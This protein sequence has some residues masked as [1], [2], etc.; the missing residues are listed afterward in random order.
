MDPVLAWSVCWQASTTAAAGAAGAA[1]AFGRPP[2]PVEAPLSATM[3]C[4]TVNSVDHHHY[5]VLMECNNQG[6]VAFAGRDFTNAS[7]WFRQGI[8]LATFLSTPS[9]RRR[10]RRRRRAPSPITLSTT[11]ESVPRVAAAA[12]MTLDGP[13]TAAFRSAAAAAAASISFERTESLQDTWPIH[14]GLE[15]CLSDYAQA[16]VPQA[17]PTS[18][19]LVLGTLYFNLAQSQRMLGDQWNEAYE[20]YHQSL[21][22]LLSSSDDTVPPSTS[23]LS[24]L[25]RETVQRLLWPTLCALAWLSYAHCAENNNSNAAADDDDT[26]GRG[27]CQTALAWYQAAYAW[28][29]AAFGPTALQVGQTLH[30]LGV[31]HAQLALWLPPPQPLSTSGGSGSMHRAESPETT[32]VDDP[33]TTTN[34]VPQ[35]A[36]SHAAVGYLQAA[37]SIFASAPPPPPPP[38]IMTM[39]VSLCAVTTAAST[40]HELGQVLWQRRDYRQALWYLQRA[41]ILYHTTTTPTTTATTSLDAARTAYHMGQAWHALGDTQSALVC[42]QLFLSNDFVQ[43]HRNHRDGTKNSN[44]YGARTTLRSSLGA[45]S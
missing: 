44:S 22:W 23:S 10:R 35:C 18:L 13:T 14:Q 20:C 45:R 2:L 43:E 5:S 42:H 7:T 33:A 21:L 3:D 4:A 9:R 28:G 26:A 40:C 37:L 1:G 38:P 24:L 15:Q 29:V 16:L 39:G 8:A 31:L 30:C 11:C 19:Y 27:G 12:A 17:A 25:N 32:A 41:Y 34:T 36:N 6:V